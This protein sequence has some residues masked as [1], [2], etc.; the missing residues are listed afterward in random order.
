MLRPSFKE[1]RMVITSE[2]GAP[3]PQAERDSFRPISSPALVRAM[4]GDG[5]EMALIDVREEGVLSEEGHPF[6]ANSVPL[7]RLELMIGE[8][9][10][11]RSV[12]IVV[13]DGGDE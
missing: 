6:F 13:H 8:L 4:L 9:V 11:R 5:G 7:S 10:P 3:V 1:T 2:D 12:R